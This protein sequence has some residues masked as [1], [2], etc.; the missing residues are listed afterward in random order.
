MKLPY[1]EDEEE[2]DYDMYTS[3]YKTYYLS[4]YFAEDGSIESFDMYQESDEITLSE[5]DLEGIEFED[6][7]EDDSDPELEDV[8]EELP[9]QPAQ[10]KNELSP[11]YKRI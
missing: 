8:N 7:P 5:E 9:L 3:D 6:E 2:V 4:V 1:Y 10:V 11:G